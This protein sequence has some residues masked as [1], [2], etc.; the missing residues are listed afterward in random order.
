MFVSCCRKAQGSTAA[1][2][3]PTGGKAAVKKTSAGNSKRYLGYLQPIETLTSLIKIFLC[4]YMTFRVISE[5]DRL[6]LD[7]GY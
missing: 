6:M 7:I 3:K 5:F 2:K 1:S 4:V